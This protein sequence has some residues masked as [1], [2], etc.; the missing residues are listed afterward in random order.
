MNTKIRIRLN[1]QLLTLFEGY[2][3]SRREI[4]EVQLEKI[5]VEEEN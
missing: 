5:K 1:L 2:F 3:N 4:F